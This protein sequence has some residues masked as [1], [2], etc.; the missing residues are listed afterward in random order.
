[1]SGRT[2]ARSSSAPADGTGPSTWFD[3]YFGRGHWRVVVFCY[4]ALLPVL[5][6][7]AY[8][9][10]VPIGNSFIL[11][12]YKWELLSKVRPFIGLANYKALLNDANFHPGAQEHLD[13]LA[14]DRHS[15]HPSRPAARHG[16]W[17]A[18]RGCRPFYQTI[19]FLPVI[20]P[21]VPMAIAWKWIY[22]YNY[23]HHELPAVAS[24]ACR[25][26]AG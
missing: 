11:S 5:R 3:R 12:F 1:M 26:S 9:R 17:P 21:M 18:S 24:S 14:L 2:T 7:S 19:Y 4:L 16:C 15:Q 22:D 10:L 13:L 20:T 23:G 8:V 25:R 6:C